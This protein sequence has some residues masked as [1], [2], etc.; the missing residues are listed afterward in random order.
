MR[1]AVE[2]LS[3]QREDYVEV[4]D[5]QQIGLALGEPS[6]CSSALALGAV[7]VPA[8]VIGDPPMP[9]VG[10]GFDMTAKGCRAA[11]LD[12]RHHLDLEKAQMPSLRDPVCGS[13]SAEDV[14]DIK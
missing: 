7:P 1:D 13:S 6:P 2:A 9:A 3:G 11:V 5:R 4:V 8:T 10:A 12:R 14:G